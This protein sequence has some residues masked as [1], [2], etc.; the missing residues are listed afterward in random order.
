[1]VQGLSECVMLY[2]FFFFF[3]TCQHGHMIG[4]NFQFN[5]IIVLCL[6]NSTSCHGFHQRK[7]V[8]LAAVMQ[9]SAR[10]YRPVIHEGWGSVSGDR[11]EWS[12]WYSFG[13][14][15]SPGRWPLAFHHSMITIFFSNIVDRISPKKNVLVFHQQHCGIMNKTRDRVWKQRKHASFIY[16]WRF[17]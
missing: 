16:Q 15:P 12:S 10:L 14:L 17:P 1:M 3:T 11:C 7:G 4:L 6:K 13:R 8:C 9:L 5:L 2:S